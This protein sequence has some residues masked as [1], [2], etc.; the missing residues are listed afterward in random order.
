MVPK[1]T[2]LEMTICELVVIEQGSRRIRRSTRSTPVSASHLPVR[3]GAVL[4]YCSPHR[5]AG[6]ERTDA[7]GDAPSDGSG[8]LRLARSRLSSW[9]AFRK[10]TG[11]M[12]AVRPSLSRTQALTFSR[13]WSTAKNRVSG[14][15]RV[16]KGAR[17]VRSETA[18][19]QETALVLPR[20]SYHIV[21]VGDPN[22][23]MPE[24]P[25]EALADPNRVIESRTE[26]TPLGT[27]SL[28]VIRAD[29]TIRPRRTVKPPVPPPQDTPPAAEDRRTGDAPAGS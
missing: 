22:Y 2:S 18:Q 27:T 23:R 11:T 8:R 6:I 5:L 7:D 1:P 19:R 26:V 16:L 28:P 15:S 13:Y 21:M 29:M 14:G 9:I 12:D 25:A 24:D 10:S 17:D 3:A 20:H 4:V